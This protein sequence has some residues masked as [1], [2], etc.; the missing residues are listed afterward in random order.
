MAIRKD[1]VLAR[2]GPE[3]LVL[4]ASEGLGRAW[5]H[6]LAAAGL[7]VVL[8]GL[9]RKGLERVARE[10][11]V[12]HGRNA[13]SVVLDLGSDA[14][15]MGMQ[16]ILSEHDIGLV[17]YNACFSKVGSF[18][19]LSLEDKLRTLR[20]NARGPLVVSHLAAE[21]F[22]ARR[23]GGLI[24]MS[25]MSGFQGGAM[26]GTYAA[27]KAFD[28]VLGETLW[29]ELAPHGVQ[30]MVCAA[31]A[32]LTPTFEASTPEDRRAGLVPLRPEEVVTEAF[33]A[34]CKGQGPTVIPGRVNK[35]VAGVVQR[36]PRGA[37][38]RFI[39]RNTRKTY[40]SR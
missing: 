19:D 29:E 12:E 22:V 26:V 36:M 8:V 21:H 37:A 33:D 28:T 3:A 13:Q 16:A 10:I 2:F 35:V 34:F 14:L 20:V 17:V 40:G 7:D 38:V 15:T 39:S 32:T 9:D 4:G 11:E 24:L 23:R 31:G 6:H 27:T 25:S 5:A 30:V 1:V 18:V